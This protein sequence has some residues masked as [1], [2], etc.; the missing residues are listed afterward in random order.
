MFIADFHIHSKYSRATSPKTDLE[1]LSEFAKIK[2]IDILATGDFTHPEWLKEIKDKLEPAEQGLYKL[3]SAKEPTRFILSS[4][5]SCI[6]SKAGSVR[7]VHIVVLAPSI[8]IVEKINLELAKIGNLKA[9]GRPI[10]GL[11]A[12]KL[13]EIVLNVSQD[14]LI[15]PAHCLLPD[16]FLH[17]NSG[18][19]MI[20]DIV[21]GD[22]VYTHK[23]VLRKVSHTFNREYQ[24]KVYNIKPY[25]FSLGLQ[26]TSEHPFYAIKTKWCPNMSHTICKKDCAYIKSKNCS[27]KYFENYHPEWVQVKDIK[28]GNIVIFP[29]FNEKTIDKNELDISKFINSS[30]YKLDGKYIFLDHSRAK[31]I[32]KLIKIDKNFC[33]LIG[34]YISEGYTDNRDS[35]SFCFARHEEKYIKDLKFLMK[36]VFNL[37]SPRIYQRENSNGTEIIYFSKI[38][39]KIFSKLFYNNSNTRRAHTKCLPLWML[40][41]PIEKQVEVFRGWWRGD[42]GVTV[43]R[44]L[45]NQMKI[46]LLRLG[47]IPS[48]SIQTKEYFNNRPSHKH[49]IGDRVI[50]AQHDSFSFHN[51]SFFQDLFGLLEDPCLEKFKT[52]INRRHGWIDEKYVYLPV[53]DIEIKNYKGKVYNL[54][55]EKDNSYLSEFAT[56]HN[57]MTPWFGVFGSK[58]GFDS[59]EECFE[60][61]TKYIYAMETGLS[62]DPATRTALES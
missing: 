47:I 26:T 15:I 32:P 54:E 31:K 62:A 19:K 33:R 16:T 46:V 23:G 57:C 53:R 38:L 36:R 1:H 30:K 34:Y 11:D 45:M 9:D 56:V 29:R 37:S 25:Y 59:L 28:K 2:G 12:K 20:K 50:R 18:I 17:T 42:A 61:Y 27:H 39:A 6:Y 55:V 10:L 3:K 51:L 52:K 8:E 4:E 21:V 48:I 60:D 58:S 7:K 44:D 40:S 13:A 41:L 14:C 43:S 5:I 24:G 22:K 49:T 35:I